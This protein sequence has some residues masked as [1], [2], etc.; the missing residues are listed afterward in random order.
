MRGGVKTGWTGHRMASDILGTS[1][2][3]SQRNRNLETFERRSFIVESILAPHAPVPFSFPLVMSTTN[4]LLASEVRIYT[5]SED[6]KVM[7]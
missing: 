3:H 4:L 5:K 7:T 6:R 2:L 1:V